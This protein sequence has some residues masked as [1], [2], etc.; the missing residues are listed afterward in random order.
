M[1]NLEGKDLVELVTILE[2]LDSMQDSSSRRAVMRQAG[3]QKLMPNLA[4]GDSADTFVTNTI[5]Y[6]GRYGRITYENE[7]LGQFLNTMKLKVG[8]DQ[9][10]RLDRLLLKY[11]MMEP[12]APPPPLSEWKSTDSTEAVLEKVFGDNTLRPIA[13]LERGLD[14]S[15]SVAYL[16]VDNGVKRWSGTGFMVTP[17]LLMTNHHVVSEAGLLGGVTVRFNYQK[18]LFDNDLQVEEHRAAPNGTFRADKT[19]DYAI[20]EVQDEPGRK[21]AWGHLPLQPRSLKP[22]ERINIIQHAG[23]QPKQ[24]SIQ[25]NM[26]EYIGGDVIQYVTSTLPGSSGSPIFNDRW[27]IVGLH[28]AGGLIAEPTTGKYFNRNEGIVI[29]KILDSLPPGIRQEIDRADQD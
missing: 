14:V 18:D 15:R 24:I 13:F 10:E 2:G 4:W 5:D 8:V 17:N 25:N 1:V 22:G 29:N 7:A 23:G 26:V 19:L 3:L 12:I 21:E 6:L 27:E 20:L 16:S 11:K 28:H 9:Q